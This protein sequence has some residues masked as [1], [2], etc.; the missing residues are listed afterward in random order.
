MARRWPHRSALDVAGSRWRAVATFM[1]RVPSL[2]AP[3]GVQ[4]PVRLWSKAQLL[5][6]RRQNAARSCRST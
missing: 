6:S 2:P 5:K 3:P 1:S 4:D